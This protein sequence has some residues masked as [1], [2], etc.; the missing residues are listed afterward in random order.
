MWIQCQMTTTGDDHKLE[1]KSQPVDFCTNSIHAKEQILK[2]LKLL[3]WIRLDLE[4]RGHKDGE[5]EHYQLADWL[6]LFLCL[7]ARC[8][9][10]SAEAIH[11]SFHSPL[12]SCPGGVFKVKWRADQIAPTLGVI[13]PWAH[14]RA[15][16]L[17]EERELCEERRELGETSMQSASIACVALA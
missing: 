16:R 12:P 2:E 14:E 4:V 11:P 3:S 6:S 15:Y 9:I 1:V 5:D 8:M 7:P 13:C 10:A 17:R